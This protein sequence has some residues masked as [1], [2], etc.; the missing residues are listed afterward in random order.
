MKFNL[1]GLNYTD[2]KIKLYI[3]LHLITIH[4]FYKGNYDS[5]IIKKNPKQNLAAQYYQCG[6]TEIFTVF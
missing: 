5:Y 6:L 1:C 4:E 3:F 2:Y